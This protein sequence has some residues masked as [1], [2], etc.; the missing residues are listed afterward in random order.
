MGGPWRNLREDLRP[1]KTA[2]GLVI[3]P[4]ERREYAA[5]LQQAVQDGEISPKIAKQVLAGYDKWKRTA[6]GAMVDY[7]RLK[8]EEKHIGME[9][10]ADK[11]IIEER[12]AQQDEKAYAWLDKS[13]AEAQEAYEAERAAYQESMAATVAAQEAA[14]ENLARREI[15]PERWWNSQSN[16]R[17]VMSAIGVAL[18]SL[19]SGL[20][21]IYGRGTPNAA[22]DIMKSAIN[23]DVTA[24]MADMRNRR[25]AVGARQSLLG[26][27]MSQVK[28]AATAQSLTRMALLDQAKSKINMYAA[29][30]QGDSARRNA[31][32]LI[33]LVDNDREIL[34]AELRMNAHKLASRRAARAKPKVPTN[35]PPLVTKYM[36]NN[37]SPRL[38][39][40]LRGGT[41]GMREKLMEGLADI[42]GDRVTL[43]KLRTIMASPGYMTSPSKQMHAKELYESIQ[44]EKRKLAHGANYTEIERELGKTGMMNE[45]AA[46]AIFGSLEAAI[47]GGKTPL[48]SYLDRQEDQWAQ[49]ASD[50]RIQR[51][52]EIQGSEIA[53]GRVTFKGKPHVATRWVSAGGPTIS[54]ADHIRLTRGGDIEQVNPRQYRDATRVPDTS[55][56]E[57]HL[58]TNR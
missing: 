20:T 9:A 23:R 33:G 42:S 15:D 10:D 52:R 43:N 11:N 47:R 24:Q 30:A 50:V 27:I 58:P 45:N 28:D 29:G 48:D 1:E 38:G 55:V 49:R 21:G 3:F 36:E 12:R 4:F 44:I 16:G 26:T 57:E 56:P 14:I 41:Q 6:W 37:Y 31:E 53:T 46:T 2:G 13:H 40:V 32:M 17:K 22:Y 39:G 34:A 25:A 19:G 7:S 18:G 8:R 51:G 5:R 35:A 54:I